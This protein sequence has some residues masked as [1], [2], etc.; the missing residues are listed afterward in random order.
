MLNVYRLMSR[1]SINNTSL[2]KVLVKSY[3]KMAPGTMIKIEVTLK[4]TGRR[5][6]TRLIDS[7][8]DN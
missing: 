6:L 3:C 1:S 8:D 2:G 4:T 5:S 7:F